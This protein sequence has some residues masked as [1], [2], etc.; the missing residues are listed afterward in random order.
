MV[1]LRGHVWKC[2]T[3]VKNMLRVVGI[4]VEIWQTRL[5]NSNVQTLGLAAPF[6]ENLPKRILSTPPPLDSANSNR[7][8][9]EPI[10]E[11]SIRTSSMALAP[12]ATNL[13]SKSPWLGRH[14]KNPRPR[15]S[16][17]KGM[18][19][20]ATKGRHRG[21]NKLGLLVG[22]QLEGLWTFSLEPIWGTNV[23]RTFSREPEIFQTFSG[24]F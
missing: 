11:A 4:D 13:Q 10:S 18:G 24:H 2:Q 7:K 22:W 5:N 12:S 3:N 20:R 17:G 16:P 6:K 23:L 15:P 8:P 1:L 14:R 19:Q 21:H 9:W